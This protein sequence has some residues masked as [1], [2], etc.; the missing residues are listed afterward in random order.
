MDMLKN[1]LL[2]I[3]LSF[4]VVASANASMRDT[5]TDAKSSSGM[6]TTAPTSATST[7]ADLELAK[8]IQDKISSGWFSKRSVLAKVLNGNVTLT[9]EVSS[10]DERTK[11]EN[12]VR[13]IKGVASIDNQI[14]V[15]EKNSAMKQKNNKSSY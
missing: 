4:G 2:A 11:I 13:E 8:K 14:T 1:S 15:K 7:S 9:G 5:L 10:A 12:Q 3:A 6:T